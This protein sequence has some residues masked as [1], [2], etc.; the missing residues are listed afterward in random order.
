MAREAPD[1]V[2][3]ELKKIANLLA[4]N[5][6]RDRPKS[7]AVV[8]LASAGFSSAE[9]AALVGTSDASVR[10]MLSQ[11]RRPAKAP[12]K[13]RASEPADGWPQG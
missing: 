7:E 1:P 11:A 12:A 4:L 6:V 8:L 5:A 10:A 2:V 9:T 13:R 3:L